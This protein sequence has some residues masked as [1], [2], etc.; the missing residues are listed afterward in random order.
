MT[1][2]KT[3]TIT[4]TVRDAELIR[5]VIRHVATANQDVQTLAIKVDEFLTARIGRP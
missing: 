3:P 5:E 1:K 4:I 2:T